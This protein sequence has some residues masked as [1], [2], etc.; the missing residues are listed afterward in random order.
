MGGKGTIRLTCGGLGLEDFFIII[1]IIAKIYFFFS[2]ATFDA[3]LAVETVRG[4]TNR[5]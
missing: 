3:R 4:K 1:I 2:P 5:H